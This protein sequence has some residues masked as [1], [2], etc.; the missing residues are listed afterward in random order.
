MPER[1]FNPH[2]P[3]YKKME[4][5]PESEQSKYVNLPKKKGDGFVTK[6]AADY[7]AR[8]KKDADEINKKRPPLKKLLGKGKV[9]AIELM[10]EEA[11]DDDLEIDIQ[12]QAKENEKK[13]KA[14]EEEEQKE[15][16]RK[17]WE[18]W[19][20]WE[21]DRLEQDEQ[22]LKSIKYIQK[23]AEDMTASI[24]K[25][26][27]NAVSGFAHTLK[28]ELGSRDYMT[29]E[30]VINITLEAQTKENP[31]P[32]LLDALV[33]VM[34]NVEKA[35]PAYGWNHSACHLFE[36]YGRGSSPSLLNHEENLP[37][38]TKLMNEGIRRAFVDNNTANL[39]RIIGPVA[40]YNLAHI[41]PEHL[42][43]DFPYRPI[44]PEIRAKL[45][46]E[47]DSE[48]E[49]QL[50]VFLT[51]DSPRAFVVCF[52]KKGIVDFLRSKNPKEVIRLLEAVKDGVGEERMAT[53]L[54][55]YYGNNQATSLE[56]LESNLEAAEASKEFVAGVYV[57][58]DGTLITM[59]GRLRK[60][61]VEKLEKYFQDGKKVI[62]FSGGSPEDQTKRLQE[63]GLSNSFL[64]VVSK[65]SF[66]GK[67]LEILIDDTPPE[68]QG[69][70]AKEYLGDLKESYSPL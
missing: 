63:L 11:L 27:M 57:D 17:A 41:S 45:A 33:D 68:Y 47:Y 61:L 7:E 36:G 24:K 2:D 4:D 60:D 32:K 53:F 39:E 5:L 67:V 62:I 54:N 34:V 9:N 69:F 28:I 29:V 55:A 18:K 58:V 15:K 14:R 49:R 50:N 13:E 65:V 22:R 8:V 52:I 16:A 59:G 31:Q 70:K 44:D 21:K 30:N 51:T 35:T 1:E 6:Q 48:H 12:K 56:E 43:A 19:E 66:R 20:K 42:D 26:G 64:P 3:K 10:H 25:E 40:A 38:A 37:A 46:P 23:N